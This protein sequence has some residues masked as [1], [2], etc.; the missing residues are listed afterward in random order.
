MRYARISGTGSYLPEKILTNDDLAQ[1]VDTSDEWITQRTGIKQR[2]IVADSE[3]TI[4]M[5]VQAAKAAIEAAAISAQDIDMII[6][7]TCTADFVFP[8][9]ACLVQSE[10]NIPNCPA[11][12]VQAA[13]SGFI[14]A[15]SI[16]QQYIRND[17]AKKVLIIGTEAMSRVIDWT[18]RSSCILFGDGAGALILEASDTPG[19]LS[20]HLGADGSYKD[21][22]YLKHNN[23]EQEYVSMQGN[24]VFKLA[25]KWLSEV[26]ETALNANKLQPSDINWVVPH[27]ANIR[28]IQST[29]KSLD[30]PLE[31]VIVTVDQHANTSAA[32]I[33][34]ALDV[35]IRDGRI[36]RGDNLLFEA[37]GGGLTWGSALV[38]Y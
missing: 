22:L 35:A 16:A 1:M 17:A 14:Y 31:K 20:T 10:L 18:N 8:S 11:F 6:V 37:F 32:S 19:I 26:A 2:H 7:A 28:I 30:I 4:S 36:R 38:R 24:T 23:I 21:V 33:P 5:A 15:L 29:V 13:C 9:S 25:V 12:D 34:L 27:Q 3:N